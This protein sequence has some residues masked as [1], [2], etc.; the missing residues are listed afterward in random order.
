MLPMNRRHTALRCGFGATVLSQAVLIASPTARAQCSQALLP[1]TATVQHSAEESSSQDAPGVKRQS[2]AV[3]TADPT[4]KQS[5]ITVLE[6]TQLRVMSNQPISSRMTKPGEPLSFTVD[7]DVAVDGLLVIPC[8]ATVRGTVVDAKKAGVLTGSAQIILELHSLEL[9]GRS[10][11]L[12]T[13]QFK[14]TGTSKTKPT[15]K[16]IKTGAVVGAIV[17]GSLSGSAHGPPTVEEKA[18]GAGAGAA[19]GAGV[20]AA[21]SAASPA[22]IV[23]IPAESEALFTLSSPVAVVPV[24]AKEAARLAR[25]MK[26]G[27]PVLYVRDE[28]Q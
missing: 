23:S 5:P 24:D 17:L 6:D 28:T 4:G 14:I 27:G 2:S 10:D 1:Q 21:V 26:P 8:G 25:G 16:K 15:E 12:Y 19:L 20:G 7:E 18:I 3:R 22:P 13:Y 11:P 9:G